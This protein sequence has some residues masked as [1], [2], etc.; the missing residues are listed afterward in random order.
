MGGLRVAGFAGVAVAMLLV[1]PACGERSEPTGKL[2]VKYPLTVQG[3]GQ[4]PLMLDQRPRRV[5]SVAPGAARIMSHLGSD[6]QLAGPSKTLDSNGR[7][8]IHR[9][10]I[11][12]PDLI[13]ASPFTDAVNLAQARRATPAPVYFAPESSIRDIER[14]ATELGLLLDVPL[15]ARRIVNEIEHRRQK[16]AERLRAVPPVRVFVDTGFF[17]TVS[18]HSL[19]G[20]LVREADGISVAGRNPEAAPFPVRRLRRIDPDVYLATSD[21]GTTLRSLR[22]DPRTRNLRAVRKGRVAVVPTRL[23]EPGPSIG[24]GLEEIARDLHPDAFR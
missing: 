22:R 11:E 16:V 3:A 8:R 5:A 21:S 20:D 2:T 9:L 24:R 6:V 10:R 14:A 13:V 4:Q 7:I 12:H 19:I 17:T 18:S 15:G 1:G 23:L